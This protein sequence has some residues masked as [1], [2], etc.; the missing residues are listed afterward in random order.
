L[1]L[2]PRTEVADRLYVGDL[3]AAFSADGTR[4]VTA[5]AFEPA[6]NI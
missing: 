3:V 1:D 2:H 4:I 6:R 5:P